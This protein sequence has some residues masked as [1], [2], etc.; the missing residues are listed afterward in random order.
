[1]AKKRMKKAVRKSR[2][3][4]RAQIKVQGAKFMPYS[5]AANVFS[6]V[7]ICLLIINAITL[8]FLKDVVMKA[9]NDA[10]TA[11][12]SSQLALMGLM[13]ILIAFF[14]WSINR[15][16]KEKQSKVAMWELFILSIVTLLTGRIE[17]GL[18]LLVASVIYLVKAKK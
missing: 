4:K 17:S 7:A 15:T 1:M 6:L 11:I 12:S 5:R 2:N 8:I 18:L 10:G 13:W 16:I 3:V 9:L 14:A